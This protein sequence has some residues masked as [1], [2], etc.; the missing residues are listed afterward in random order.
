MEN[1]KRLAVVAII[2]DDLSV[3]DKVN[4]LLHD[5]CDYVVGRM[6]IPYKEKNLSVISVVIDAPQ[7][8][9]NSLTGKLGMIQGV[10]AK[11][12]LSNK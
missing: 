6:G 2:V 5:I 12:L 9:I 8:K 7:D 3:S 11:V 10:T 1:N 4:T